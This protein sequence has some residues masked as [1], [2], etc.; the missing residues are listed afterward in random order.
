MAVRRRDR[1]FFQPNPRRKAW[2]RM[3]AR[4]LVADSCCVVREGLRALLHNKEG[5]R[6]VAEARTA[7]ETVTLSRKHEPD[8]ILLEATMPGMNGAEITKAI[9]ARQPN[10]RIIGLNMR[11]EEGMFETMFRAGAV[12][13]MIKKDAE[14][15]EIVLAVKTVLGGDFYVGK[16][17]GQLVA[18]ETILSRI[19]IDRKAKHLKRLT[20]REREVYS[21]GQQG[22]YAKQ[23]A[24]RLGV[25]VRTVEAYRRQIKA[26]LAVDSPAVAAVENSG[27]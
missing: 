25:T 14:P 10:I 20:R 26:K 21:L 23:V 6:I 2:C 4:V 11:S 19:G 27:L 24:A 16:Y 8:V 22:F 15:K 18:E 3:K 17:A 9:L 13:F 12:G 7:E 1:P 5:M